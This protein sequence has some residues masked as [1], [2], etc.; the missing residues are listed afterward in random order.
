EQREAEHV[1]SKGETK[2]PDEMTVRELRE[3]KRQ[4]RAEQTE[5]ERLEKENEELANKPPEVVTKYV[6]RETKEYRDRSFDTPHGVKL[7]DDFYN[8]MDELSDWQRK[9]A[10]ITSD[11]EQLKELARV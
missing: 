9:Y 7:L 1:T 5:R 2:T 6:E 3:L 10:W 11:I 4:L 8:A